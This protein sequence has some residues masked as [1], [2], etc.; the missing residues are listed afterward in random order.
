MELETDTLTAIAM[1]G[2]EIVLQKGEQLKGSDVGSQGL[3]LILEGDIKFY[4]VEQLFDHKGPGR[5]FGLPTLFGM[6]ASEF[7]IEAQAKT[8]LMRIPP[9]E[10][11]ACVMD[12][13]I[14][15]IRACEK[16]SQVQGSLMDNIFKDSDDVSPT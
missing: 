4:R 12:H 5:Y 3:F 15:A 10:F 9:D 7:M 6:E 13:P 1:L 14:I 11:R 2:E 16:L 8:T